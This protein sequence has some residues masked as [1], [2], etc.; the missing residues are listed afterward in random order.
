VA[1]G[2]LSK[3][4][5]V[6]LVEIKEVGILVPIIIIME[7]IIRGGILVVVRLM[8]IG[9]GGMSR[10]VLCEAALMLISCIKRFRQW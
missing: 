4:S 9:I 8:R 10:R 6:L 2:T 3:G 1:I 5:R 7:E